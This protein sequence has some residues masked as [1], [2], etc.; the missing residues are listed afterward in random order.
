VRSA[1]V[2]RGALGAVVVATAALVTPAL[3]TSVPPVAAAVAPGASGL[4]SRTAAGPVPGAQSVESVISGDGRHIAFTSR[5]DF[6]GIANDFSVNVYTRDLVTGVTAQMSI[7]HRLDGAGTPVWDR[8]PDGDSS[9][10]A[11]SADGRYVAFVTTATDITVHVG[12][13]P[14][15]PAPDVI[16]RDRDS[17]GNGVLDDSPPRFTRVSESWY[18]YGAPSRPVLSADGGRVLWSDEE[19][20][21]GGR[22][23]V[24]YYRD[25]AG[26]EI[27][28][29][30]TAVSGDHAP[31]D[32][33]YQVGAYDGTLSADGTH[34]A[35][36]V[37]FLHSPEP[38]VR[39]RPLLRMG[40]AQS[41]Y[42]PDFTAIVVVELVGPEGPDVVTRADFDVDGGFLGVDRGT[43]TRHPA[44]SADGSVV[45]F[46]A[47]EYTTGEGG[48]W[49][50]RADQP[51]VY[52]AR[53]AEERSEVV[54]RD[55]GGE[56]ANGAR[57]AL[58]ADAR[59]VAFVTDSLDMHDGLDWGTDDS[60]CLHEEFS[61]AVPPPSEERDART[62]C[63]VVVRDLVLDRA[64][65]AAGAERLPAVLASPGL[66]RGCDEVLPPTEV[67]AG[68]G[69]SGFS[70]STRVLDFGDGEGVPGMAADGARVVFDSFSENLTADDAATDD[71]EPV[72]EWDGFT[73]TF[74]PTLV[75]DP[76]DF[77]PADIGSTLT[78]T[79][80]LRVEGAGPVT[81]A[82]IAVDGT[83]FTAG[84]DTCAGTT[85]HREGTCLAGVAFSPSA[86]GARA[87]R[88]LVRL[89]DGREVAV[90]LRGTGSDVP[91]VPDEPEFTATPSPV[92]FGARLLLSTDPTATVTIT[93]TG[94]SPMALTSIA[95]AAPGDFTVVSTDCAV[96]APAASCAAVVRFRPTLPG[97]RTGVL[98]VDGDAPGG[99][100]LVGLSGSGSTPAL[101]VNPGVSK[102][103][104][105]VSVSGK[106]FP[107]SAEVTVGYQE[108][109]ETATVVTSN[110]GTFSVSLMVF[111]KAS[112]GQRTVKA[113]VDG[114]AAGV[115]EP[116]RLLVVY[117]SMSP[118]EFLTRG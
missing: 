66:D 34:V 103:G 81:V 77:G 100:H 55:T 58:S 71:G 80:T 93:N 20:G 118:P 109:V 44:L 41:Y 101:L 87:G 105:V 49:Y 36:A 14:N 15:D 40:G 24:V 50:P 33:T 30:L 42:A 7:G 82:S 90:D 107:A 68:D 10:P 47:E 59:Y 85:L 102:P 67:C 94:G 53:L 70:D 25:L 98:R 117:P 75:A 60:S 1:A 97:P 22:A 5:A 21:E 79:A 31:A 3:V 95:P 106:G 37:D 43:G 91:V 112:V 104:R 111:P 83:D 29:P 48:Y 86:A 76:V 114:L 2:R 72:V 89:A 115:V 17:D 52:V 32:E 56:P 16:V 27:A 61:L 84:P 39:A 65:E 4:V 110:E 54:S 28:G 73:R 116:G 92:D 113:T 35:M 57:P 9:Q 69:D 26:G 6:A 51:T 62:H 18:Y 11:L 88:L 78:R 96:V 8:S 38:G 74:L 46:E 12:D 64:R 45:A 13:I 63:Q 108:S 19:Y 99:P 23:R